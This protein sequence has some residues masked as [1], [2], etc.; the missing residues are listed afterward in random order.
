MSNVLC[1]FYSNSET[2]SRLSWFDATGRLALCSGYSIECPIISIACTRG[3]HGLA[4]DC[5]V[6]RCS[7]VEH[8]LIHYFPYFRHVYGRYIRYP[9]SLYRVSCRGLWP[10][11]FRHSSRIR[12]LRFSRYILQGVIYK[13]GRHLE[14]AV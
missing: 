13:Y 7:M 6:F 12:H 1:D 8:M 9:E 5:V 4:E 14:E 3:I 11:R 10:I 2:R